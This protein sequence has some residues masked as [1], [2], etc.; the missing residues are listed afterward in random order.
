MVE[1]GFATSRAAGGRHLRND[2]STMP[3]V[4]DWVS[5]LKREPV[6]LIHGVVERRTVF[7]RKAASVETRQQVL[8]ANADVA[9]VVSASTDV[10]SRRIERYPTKALQIHP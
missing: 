1:A 7:A 10:N 4:G 9:C 2:G 8:A 6:D 3:A 5:G